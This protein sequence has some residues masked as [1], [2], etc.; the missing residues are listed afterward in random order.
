MFKKVKLIL[1][2]C[3]FPFFSVDAIDNKSRLSVGGGIYNFMENGEKRCISLHSDSTCFSEESIAKT[4]ILYQ[5]EYQS[6]KRIFKIFKPKIGFL[7]TSEDA[8]YGYGGLAVD[9][10]FGDCKCIVLTPSF[11]AGWYVDGDEIKMY[12]RLEFMSGGDISYRFRNNVR[13]GVG[14]YH[15]SNAGLGT[16]NPGSESIILKY[17]I[18]F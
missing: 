1:F 9:F 7:G 11:A 13:V 4:S 2:F 18:P 16:E 15:I 8:L 12:N 5:L 10:Y 3:L 6:P 14:I 17:Q